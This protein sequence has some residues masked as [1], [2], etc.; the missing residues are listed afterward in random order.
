[1][2]DRARFCSY[3]RQ[4]LSRDPDQSL[5]IDFQLAACREF[6]ARQGG[7]IVGEFSDPDT[8]GWKRHRPGF[9]AMLATIANGTA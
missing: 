5:S 2:T 9:D 1:M 6:V 8:K 7:V 4:S 3:A